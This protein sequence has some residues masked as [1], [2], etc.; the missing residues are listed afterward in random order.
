M[1]RVIMSHLTHLR[2]FLEAYRSGS[3]SR[4]AQVLGI[5]QP[6]ASQHIQSLEV[7]TGKRLFIREARGV[8]AT[9]AADELARAISPYIMAWQK[10]CLPFALAL[11]AGGR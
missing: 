5:S 4:A 9:E 11:R 6:A 8:K 7:L 2:T 3:F 1:G 10:N